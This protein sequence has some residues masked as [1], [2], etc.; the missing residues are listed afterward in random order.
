MYC[1]NAYCANAYI[2]FRPDL[3]SWEKV[4]RLS[5]LERLDHAFSIAKKHLGI[6]KLLDPEGNVAEVFWNF[7]AIHVNC[8]TY[9][10]LYFL[11]G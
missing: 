5:P 11:V 4:T 10:Y 1:A 8:T 2:Y 6:E 9:S 3:F 7:I